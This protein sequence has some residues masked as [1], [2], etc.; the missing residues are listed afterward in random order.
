MPID[1]PHK[2]LVLQPNGH[3][4]LSDG[5][6]M[7]IFPALAD[8][9]ADTSF[10]MPTRVVDLVTE[11]AVAFN[12]EFIDGRLL[13]VVRWPGGDV[14]RLDGTTWPEA[15]AVITNIAAI[16]T[17]KDAREAIEETARVAAL[18]YDQ[19]RARAYPP[20]ADFNDAKVKQASADPVMVADGQAQETA[21]LQACL[22]VKALYPKV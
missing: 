5:S 13:H 12:Y 10:T 20:T 3:V 1:I 9:L 17:A 18:P 16:I 2:A 8:F 6:V 19:R 22:D 11:T 21:Y 14:S 4:L 7:T 15:D